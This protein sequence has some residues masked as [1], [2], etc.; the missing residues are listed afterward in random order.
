ML[1][2]SMCQIDCSCKLV[3]LTNNEICQLHT[4]EATNYLIEKTELENV[5]I[6][7]KNKKK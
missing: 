6:Y 5:L 1:C 7:L 3:E 4:D 2:V